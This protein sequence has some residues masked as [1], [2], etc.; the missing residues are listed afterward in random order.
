MLPLMKRLP[1]GISTF[2]EMI[3]EECIYVDK[4]A[5][6]HRLI[7]TGKN[8]F[9]SRP[10]RFGKSVLISTLEAI[11]QGKKEL[12]NGLAIAS[13]DYDFGTY[14]VLILDLSAIDYETISEFRGA[15]GGY[16]DE[17]GESYGIDL[18]SKPQPGAKLR[19]LITK[20]AA[21]G[22]VVVLVDEYDKPVTDFID[23]P[24]I[25]N[26]MRDLLARFSRF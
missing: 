20:L 11:F 18:S 13:T 22:P 7:T 23:E 21:K 15:L 25:A 3:A 24:A 16:I 12:F 10:R 26:Q 8:F 6:L 5:F 2:A 4:T 9:L 14:P 1:I 19:Y 17:L